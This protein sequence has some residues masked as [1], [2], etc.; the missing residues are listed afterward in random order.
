MLVSGKISS[1]A[2]D[3]GCG[4][5]MLRMMGLSKI[6]GIDLRNGQEVTV[7]ASAEYLPFRG[8]CFQLVFA[9]EVI[10]HLDAPGRALGDWVRVL[11]KGG[12]II[13]S[14]PNGLLV[15]RSW[16]P[17]HRRMLAPRDLTKTMRRLG[18]RVTYAKG[19]FIALLPGRRIFR[20]IPFDSVKML[21]LR[22]PVPISL[23]YDLFI[24]AEK[25][26]D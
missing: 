4:A 12:R 1:S 17:D 16:N 8:Q 5:G 23:S 26:P 25:R 14:T 11:E 7:L 18:L 15:S 6:I 3:V 9:G 10:E 13:V 21:L 20:W 22:L 19:F 24:S 2:L